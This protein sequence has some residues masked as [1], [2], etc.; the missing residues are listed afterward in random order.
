M[1]SYRL[2]PIQAEEILKNE[3]KII[4]LLRKQ[5]I[6]TVGDLLDKDATALGLDENRQKL[7]EGLV[8]LLRFK[9]EGEFLDFYPYF[10]EK[11]FLSDQKTIC[12]HGYVS[13]YRMG[14]NFS[15]KEQLLSNGK[16]IIE[17]HGC[18]D[19]IA[20]LYYYRLKFPTSSIA[21]KID[22]YLKGYEVLQNSREENVG[23]NEELQRLYRERIEID[24]R[25]A[26]IDMRIQ[27]LEKQKK[28]T[29]TKK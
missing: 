18:L 11:I 26:E 16:V 25:R 10:E 14:I 13:F 4:E 1:E 27:E 3:F 9:Y 20:F 5:N 21:P 8:R 6:K 22:I 15:E 24:T 17:E 7:L 2:K 12:L 29:I 23:I 28:I 19:F